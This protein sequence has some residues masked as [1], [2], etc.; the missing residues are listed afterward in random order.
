MTSFFS[1]GLVPSLLHSIYLVSPLN[2]FTKV[3]M[4]SLVTVLTAVG[5]V[6]TL[7]TMAAVVLEVRAQQRGSDLPSQRINLFLQWF[8]EIS[9]TVEP[10]VARMID[11]FFYVE[12]ILP[13]LRPCTRASQSLWNTLKPDAFPG[14]YFISGFFFEYHGLIGT[15]ILSFVF[16]YFYSSAFH[17]NDQLSWL[18]YDVILKDQSSFFFCCSLAF[19]LVFLA[20]S[21]RIEYSVREEEVEDEKRSWKG[22][23]RN[24]VRPELLAGTNRQKERSMS[25]EDE[26]E[27]EM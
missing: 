7:T 8:H 4:M 9:K 14:Y 21:C 15:G 17:V 5:V 11:P 25:E 20:M 3:G 19:L 1:S 18:I 2:H 13:Y 16:L 24:Y 23:T 26:D 27:D 12:K 22:R 6:S 10:W